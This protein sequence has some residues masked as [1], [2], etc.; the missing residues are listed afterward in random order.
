MRVYGDEHRLR[1]PQPGRAA[2]SA[3]SPLARAIASVAKRYL[4][5][6]PIGAL[7]R[8]QG[9]PR[10]DPPEEITAPVPREPADALKRVPTDVSSAPA[11]VLV[12]F[13]RFDDRSWRMV[14]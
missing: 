14:V 10:P 3:A 7:D 2:S 1:R 9:D 8:R 5:T 13:G 6:A 11:D 12:P 4:A